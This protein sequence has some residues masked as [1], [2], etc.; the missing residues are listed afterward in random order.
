MK[1]KTAILGAM[2]GALVSTVTVPS[3]AEDWSLPIRA[4]PRPLT[5]DSVPHVQLDVELN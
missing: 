2:M 5:T 4:N 1:I 3:W